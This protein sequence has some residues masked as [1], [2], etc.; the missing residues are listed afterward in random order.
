MIAQRIQVFEWTEPD[1]K[2][3]YYLI[4]LALQIIRKSGIAPLK[5]LTPELCREAL[6]L[7]EKAPVLDPHYVAAA[8]L[9]E[10]VI[11]IEVETPEG[12]RHVIIDGWHRV[13]K[14]VQTNHTGTLSAYI[15]PPDI[16]EA[17]RISEEQNETIRQTFARLS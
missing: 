7:N 9:S 6:V 1:G 10:P 16:A 5:V 15:V 14:A 2:Q 17:F 12:N 4:P 3:R 13:T 8:D 11:I